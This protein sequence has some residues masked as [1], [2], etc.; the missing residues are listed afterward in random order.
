MGSTSNNLDRVLVSVGASGKIRNNWCAQSVGIL[1]RCRVS[2]EDY[3]FVM[4]YS[5]IK[6]RF[7]VECDLLFINIVTKNSI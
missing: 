5:K 3:H 7:S 2:F 1:A 4:Y 6:N